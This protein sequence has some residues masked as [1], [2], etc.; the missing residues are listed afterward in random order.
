MST[1]DES[2]GSGWERLVGVR[3]P[4]DAA[5]A[6]IHSWV[7]AMLGAPVV[8]AT[9]RV[10]GMSPAVAVS[11]RA[12]NGSRAFVKAVSA[13]I[14]PDTPNHFR[15][16][17]AV[18]GALPPAPYRASLLSTYDDGTWVA[19]ALEDVDG[20]HPDWSSQQDRHLVFE[21]VREQARELTPIPSGLPSVSNRGGITKCLEAMA[22]PTPDEL[23]GLPDWAR[24]NLPRLRELGQGC[25]RHQR[26]ESFCHWDLRHDNILIRHRDGQP[27][28][29][30]WG[31]SRRGQRWGD[32]VVFALQ[33]VDSPFFDD[34]VSAAGRT[35]E[36]EADVT[37]FVAALGCY[38]LMSAV[39]P[40]PPAL[41]TLPAFRRQLGSACLDG[42]R[43]RLNA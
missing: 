32:T 43:R 23:A 18:L 14:N 8:E 31:M 25:L 5:P 2:R 29:L 37:G 3:R 12:A 15:H 36:E 40:P 42:V 16:E 35:E 27:L 30:D 26:D 4:Y 17:M 34:I 33:W 1:A 21:A 6:A 28:L 10:G 41:P 11:L 13:D 22:D 20:R 9:P 24:T 39:H 38:H 19:I 7:E